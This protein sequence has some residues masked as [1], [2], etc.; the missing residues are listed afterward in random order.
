[1]TIRARV[2]FP[3]ECVHPKNLVLNICNQSSTRPMVVSELE[4]FAPKSVRSEVSGLNPELCGGSKYAILINE[5]GMRTVSNHRPGKPMTLF[6]LAVGG[7]ACNKYFPTT[8]AEL[9]N[10][11]CVLCMLNLSIKGASRMLDSALQVQQP[12]SAAD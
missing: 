3:Q 11:T 2:S 5:H 1:M 10:S 12:F 9:T 6:S 4:C 7:R 8:R